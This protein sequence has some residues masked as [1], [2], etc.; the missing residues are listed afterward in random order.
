MREIE[1]VDVTSVA[2]LYAALTLVFSLL[3]AVPWM[4]FAGSLGATRFGGLE[5][6]MLLFASVLVPVLYGLF[7]FVADALVAWLYN[8]LA[9]RMGGI[10]VELSPAGGRREPAPVSEAGPRER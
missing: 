9:G 7:A 10:E 3:V 5:A 2:K 6:G 4:V 8:V 1:R